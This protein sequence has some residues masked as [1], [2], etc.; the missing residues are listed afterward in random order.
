MT[1]TIE[2]SERMALE[3]AQ[4]A[5]MAKTM[6]TPILD[7]LVDEDPRANDLS[8][9]DLAAIIKGCSVKNLGRRF[10]ELTDK[11]DLFTHGMQTMYALMGRETLMSMGMDL[12]SDVYVPQESF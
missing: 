1:K 4:G 7:Q 5:M 11:N 12:P 2:M 10:D 8:A 9:D 3:F 6:L